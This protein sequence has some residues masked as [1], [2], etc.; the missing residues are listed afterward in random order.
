M[1]LVPAQTGIE[2][3][4]YSANHIKKSVV[5][6]GHADK[7]QIHAMVEILLPGCAI[8]GGDAADALAVAICH[9]HHVSSARNL[10]R[11]L[12]SAGGRET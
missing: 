6:T 9:A 2:V 1:L 11:N 7:R 3:A 5:G 10:Q 8:N 4:E 12:A